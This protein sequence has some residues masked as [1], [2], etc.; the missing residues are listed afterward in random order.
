M[1]GRYA[2]AFWAAVIGVSALIGSCLGLLGR[3]WAE[4]QFRPPAP[5]VITRAPAPTAASPQPGLPPASSPAPWATS[6]P[7][8]R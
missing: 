8:P 5:I 3:E 7:E 2:V 6:T 4:E 1:G